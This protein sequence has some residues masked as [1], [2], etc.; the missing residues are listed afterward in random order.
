MPWYITLMHMFDD[1]SSVEDAHAETRPV[2]GSEPPFSYLF[3]QIP[4]MISG[5]KD[6]PLEPDGVHLTR[7]ISV[8]CY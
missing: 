3:K 7:T 4:G 5:A 2:L 6:R 8:C 1:D